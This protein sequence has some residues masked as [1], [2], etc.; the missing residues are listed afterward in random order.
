MG[1][2]VNGRQI[3]ATKIGSLSGNRQSAI[4]SNADDD[5]STHIKPLSYMPR[6]SDAIPIL[7]HRSPQALRAICRNA[8]ASHSIE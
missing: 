2:S 7:A 8:Q 3:L 6:N 5:Q 1:G 4:G